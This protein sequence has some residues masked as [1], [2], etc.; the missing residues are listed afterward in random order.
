LQ[1]LAFSRKSIS[2]IWVI[3]VNPLHLSNMQIILSFKFTCTDLLSHTRSLFSPSLF[4]HTFSF[5]PFSPSLPLFHL[6]HLFFLYSLIFSPL[7]FLSPSPL[8]TFL[9]L[10]LFYLSPFLLSLLSHHL[11]YIPFSFPPSLPYLTIPP[12]LFHFPSLSFSLTSSFI[13]LLSLSYLTFPLSPLS[14]F[15]YVFISVFPLYPFLHPSISVLSHN[16]PFSSLTFSLSHLFLSTSSSRLYLFLLLPLCIISHLPFL[17]FFLSFPF[18]P[19]SSLSSLPLYL[20]LYLSPS[21]A[22]SHT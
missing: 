1:L 17:S 18:L 16:P 7:P 13:L 22:L 12:L 8:Y 5:I 2:D 10:S 15:P 4:S 19:L 9:L 21:L 3:F 6:F 20:F 14:Y 11:L